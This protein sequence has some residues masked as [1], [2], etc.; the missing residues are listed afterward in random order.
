MRTKHI[1]TALAL[2]A[3][4]AACTADEF[5][6]VNQ[7]A[8]L[9]EERAK[10]AEN[11]TLLTSG[12]QTRYAVEGGAGISFNFEKGD[13]IGAAIIDQ[14]DP[15]AEKPEDFEVIYSLAGNNPFE[16]QG[17]DEWKSNTQLGIGHY[18]FVYPYNVSDNNRAA[19][20]YELPVIQELGEGAEG[21]NAAIEKGNKA[22]AAAVLH[23]GEESVDISLKNLF[24]YPKLTINF[25]NGEDV[26]TV[27]QIVLKANKT[28][29]AF[30]VKG[31]FNHKVLSAMFNPDEEATG[32]DATLNGVNEDKEDDEKFY[33]KKDGA[34][35]P[36]MDWDKVGTYDFLIDD[37]DNNAEPYNPFDEGRTSDYIIVKFPEGTAVK[38]AANTDNKYVEARIMMPSIADL[39][40][41]ENKYTLYVYTDNGVYHV[42]FDKEAFSFSDRTDRDKIKAAL[43]RSA[44]NGLTL[45]ALTSENKGEDAGT[46]VTTLADWN[47]LV[48]R[49]GD[50][51]QNQKI[52]IVGDDFAFDGAKDIEWPETCTFTIDTD[53]TV[54]GN[55]EMKN[56]NVNGTINV[57][58]GATLTV[59]NTL[60]AEEEVEFGEGAETV[61]VETKIVNE[62]TVVIAAEYD[63]AAFDADKKTK[64]AYTGISSIE[65]K[66][67]LVVNKEAKAEFALTNVQKAVV[68]NN[69]EVKLSNDTQYD[70]V[71]DKNEQ[72]NNGTINNNGT[73]RTGNFTN[74][75]PE[76][77][78]EGTEDE[79]IKNMPVINNA[80]GARMV[81]EGNFTNNA[82]LVNEGTLACL[83][84]TTGTITN[85]RTLDSKKGAVT[86][87]TNN[88]GKVVVYEAKP[89]TVTINGVKDGQS[90]GA[91]IVE[92]ETSAK[93]EDFKESLVNYVIA[94]GDLTIAD[95][96]ISMLT[97]KGDAALTLAKP[98]GTSTKEGKINGLTI[99]EGNVVLASD[100]TVG[101]LEIAEKGSLNVPGNITMTYTGDAENYNNEGLIL[102][103]GTFSATNVDAAE[104]GAVQNNGGEISWAK[105]DAEEAKE[106]HDAAM[107]RMVQAQI[108]ANTVGWTGE[109]GVYY[110]IGN[111]DWNGTSETHET[112]GKTWKELL[113][114]AVKLYNAWKGASLDA[115]TYLAEVYRA[116]SDGA[117]AIAEV[118]EEASK[119]SVK[120]AF[121]DVYPDN[122]WIT[123][124]GNGYAEYGTFVRSSDEETVEAKDIVT[125]KGTSVA[126]KFA[127][128][129]KKIEKE[130]VDVS[131]ND[132][133]IE[134]AVE[135][136]SIWLTMQSLGENGENVELSYIPEY[137]YIC[138]YEGADEYDVVAGLK[139]LAADLENPSGLDKVT[140]NYTT[141]KAI[142]EAVSQIKDAVDGNLEDLTSYEKQ[143]ATRSG[144]DKYNDT[145]WN[146]KFTDGQISTLNE[147]VK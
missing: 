34:T 26:T 110:K 35:K 51:K 90:T 99:E 92:Y 37:E 116:E 117:K 6:T 63:K 9:Q 56:V 19:V 113:D 101:T 36:S 108:L 129:A 102:V 27:S 93:S 13:Q 121:N 50:T 114:D 3:L 55:V 115:D 7:N 145:V 43:A 15:Y 5:E 109:N 81:A 2:P 82:T 24:T 59:N 74:V 83:N 41:L 47:D 139:K 25:D 100:V 97:F 21:L 125:D 138:V 89:L 23:E 96:T 122:T 143:L 16:F 68:T 18:L 46:I 61:E 123:K 86:Y 124:A 127:E 87:I 58:K 64:N 85:G 128:N 133:A 126:A 17:N 107:R 8:G 30:I 42:D 67:D 33:Y 120:A 29:D 62:G 137:S 31:G 118:Y 132:N 32:G 75:K 146:W 147:K 80:K 66:G 73:L 112:I 40:K 22:V 57:E 78:D 20:A 144:L 91:G 1:L 45:K 11:F 88:N 119:K 48:D 111:G 70:D 39:T 12:I 53:V 131:T 130:E 140:N 52:I 10:V 104:G 49:F 98:A 79:V 14:Y 38:P 77:E 69:G 95:G 44:S 106:K 60:S 134:K 76:I 105:T 141:L 54:K 72:G 28:E 84:T 135:N 142:R 94:S 71:K 103:G 136:Q 4:F 65:N